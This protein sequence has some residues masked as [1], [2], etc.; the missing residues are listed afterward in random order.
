[1]K[2]LWICLILTSLITILGIS[3]YASTT[4]ALSAYSEISY[5]QSVSG[6][7]YES[8]HSGQ[9]KNEQDVKEISG[10]LEIRSTDL[11]LPGKPD[12][13]VVVQ[14]RYNSMANNGMESKKYGYKYSYVNSSGN[15]KYCY[16]L[17]ATEQDMYDNAND[18]FVACTSTVL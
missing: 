3:V 14:R 7:Q 2:K 4:D 12:L 1:M 5:A 10:A 9:L 17:F 16:V 8:P 15:T 13:D 11:V 18:S 6:A